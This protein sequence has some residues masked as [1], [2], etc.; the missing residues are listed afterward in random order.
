MFPRTSSLVSYYHRDTCPDNF[1]RAEIN[2]LTS[3]SLF[4]NLLT[5][6]PPCKTQELS[7]LC[8]CVSDRDVDWS[9]L[10][11]SHA[12]LEQ[13]VPFMCLNQLSRRLRAR[14][15]PSPYF[16]PLYFFS[17]FVCSSPLLSFSFRSCNFLWNFLQQ[18]YRIFFLVCFFAGV[19]SWTWGT[20]SNL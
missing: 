14:P 19:T 12:S 2:C 8:V 13:S 17:F 6:R 5:I 10:S 7:T 3:H 11:W 16:L 1:T 4:Q 9:S 18:M 20:T 15:D